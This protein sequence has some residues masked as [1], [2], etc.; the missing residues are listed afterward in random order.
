[1]TGGQI[2]V[3]LH[4]QAIDAALKNQWAEALK[5]NQ[6]IIAEEPE[7]VECLNRLAKAYFELGDLNQ[8]Q[9]LYKQ[10]MQLDPYNSIAQKNLKKIS[11]CKDAPQNGMNRNGAATPIISPSFFLSE[12]GLTKSVN[13]LK[14]AEPQKILAMSAGMM[15]NLVPK[16]RG[17][18]ITDIHNNYVG[19]LPDDLS[20]H[21]MKLIDG[22]NKYQA[23]IQSIK[24]NSV[25][26]LIRE[27]FRSKK[28]K[29]QA[30]FLEESKTISY[31][32]DHLTLL[33]E[34]DEA[35]VEAAQAENDDVIS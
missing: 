3:N 7:N 23:Y 16:S 22:G 20:F 35:P 29:N 32:S 6:Q 12:P 13:L 28:F 1:M 31:S 14:V 10:V 26:I 8:S 15:L 21:L 24:V 9:K 11:S 5:L 19:V 2:T 33:T 30:S 18:S 4:K 17:I 34:D 25:T 27:V